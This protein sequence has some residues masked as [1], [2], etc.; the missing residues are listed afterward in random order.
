M[1]IDHGDWFADK[2]TGLCVTVWNVPTVT[3]CPVGG[4]VETEAPQYIQYFA[5]ATI[6]LQQLGQ[7]GPD[8]C[9]GVFDCAPGASGEGYVGTDWLLFAG[10]TGVGWVEVDA[11]AAPDGEFPPIGRNPFTGLG[12]LDIL[13]SLFFIEYGYFYAVTFV[14]VISRQIHRKGT[15][16]SLDKG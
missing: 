5:P 13:F 14:S 1:K 8:E 7:V 6:G 9:N 3:A 16:T 15:Q 10:V 2:A 4:G 11:G 12:W